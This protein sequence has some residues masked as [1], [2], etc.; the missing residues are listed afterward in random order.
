M[1]AMLIRPC[2]CRLERR[3]IRHGPWQWGPELQRG[4]GKLMELFDPQRDFAVKDGG[5]SWRAD[6]LDASISCVLEVTSKVC[7]NPG[8]CMLGLSLVKQRKVSFNLLPP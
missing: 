5:L 8:R 6:W 1:M 7:V 2:G 3:Q 4:E